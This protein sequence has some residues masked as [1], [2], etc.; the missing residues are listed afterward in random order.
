[1]LKPGYVERFGI[2]IP[3]L[4]DS[5]GRPIAEQPEWMIQ[6]NILKNY[7]ALNQ[8]FPGKLKPRYEHMIDFIG[9]IWGNP[10]CRF[11]FQMNPNAERII[12]AYHE[13]RY[14]AVAGHASSGKSEAIAVLAVSEFLIDPENTR[15]MVTSTDA[16][17]AK[18]KVFGRIE[19]CWNAAV[20]FYEKWEERFS[21]IGIKGSCFAPG[22]LISSES[23][24][25]RWD[26][27]FVDNNRG[28]ELIAAEASKSAEA[29]SKMQ[30]TKAPRL[31]LFADE[32]ATIAHSVLETATS[33]LRMNAGFRCVGAFNPSSYFDPAGIMS[34]PRDGWDSITEE[35]DEWPTIIEPQGIEGYC[36]KFDGLK[37]P[38]VL[39][40]REVYKGLLTIEQLNSFRATLGGD[41]TKLFMGQV[42]GFWSSGGD[43][44]SIYVESEITQYLADRPVKNWLDTPIMLAG[45]DPAF[46]HGGDRAILTIGR[47]GKARNIDT[48]KDILI[49]E[50]VKSINLDNDITNKSMSKDEW[51]VKLLKEKM[52]EY[53]ISVNNLSVDTTGAGASFSSLVRRDIGTGFLDVIFNSSPSDM[54]YSAADARTGKERFSN[55]MSEMWMVGKELIRAGQLRNLDP[56]CIN[57][58]CSRTYVDTGGKVTVEP[59]AKMK[60]RT[61]KSPDVADSLFTVLHLARLRHGLRSTER[62]APRHKAPSAPSDK[63]EQFWNPKPRRSNFHDLAE[64]VGGWVGAGWGDGGL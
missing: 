24:I 13:H 44:E 20:E 43:K 47:I 48:G 52:T 55:L 57:E 18:S 15:A 10:E 39:A 30:G 42:R 53:G 58:M 64:S 4:V 21:K 36:I 61:R 46:A 34:R 25:R 17:S 45:L 14:L 12:K 5:S 22:R 9:S 2:I 35:S 62:A 63:L 31:L 29:S 51:V 50:K 41:K 54:R 33:N 11:Y 16:K 38:N 26:G 6:R 27:R 32:L 40:G 56:D 1:M 28:I 60:L 7:D 19:N 8:K 49:F 59:K 37:S 3:P 23:V